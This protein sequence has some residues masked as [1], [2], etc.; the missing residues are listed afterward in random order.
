MSRVKRGK[1]HLKRR[2]NLLK[3]VK[4][5]QGGRK[6]LIKLAKVADLKAGAYAY[7]DR[8]KKK[9]NMRRLWQVRINAAARDMGVSYSVLMG[10]LKKHNVLL[11][12]KVLSEI[13]MQYPAVFKKIAESAK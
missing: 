13:A 7:S 2:K 11:D 12:R 4:G 6:K 1:M 5:F 9:R 8:R 10:T 3:R